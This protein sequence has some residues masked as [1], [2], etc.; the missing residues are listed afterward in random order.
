[1]KIFFTLSSPHLIK[2]YWEVRTSHQC[3]IANYIRRLEQTTRSLLKS[4]ITVNTKWTRN[5]DYIA[6][7]LYLP[8]KLKMNYSQFVAFAFNLQ[9]AWGCSK[10]G[11]EFRW[12]LLGER[13]SQNI[14]SGEW[15][16]PSDL[17]YNTS[18]AAPNVLGDLNCV[19]SLE[20]M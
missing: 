20:I 17:D 2:T 6:S 5:F 12:F 7:N 15:R 19:H 16:W 4:F 1:M 18:F 13:F 3:W 11:F 14:K 9:H 8:N 10:H